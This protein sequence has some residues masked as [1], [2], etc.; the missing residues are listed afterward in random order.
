MKTLTIFKVLFLILLP[1]IIHAQDTITISL[2]QLLSEQTLPPGNYAG[3]K[4][5][6]MV[7][8]IN[9]QIKV[10]QVDRLPAVPSVPVIGGTQ[11]TACDL[12]PLINKYTNFINK[13]YID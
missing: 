11:Q 2:P 12:D 8:T 6:G 1:A 13:D 7:P 3:I 10:E 9:Y 5:E 4:I